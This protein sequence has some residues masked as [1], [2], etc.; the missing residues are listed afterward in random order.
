MQMAP[1]TVT[2]Q[3]GATFQVCRVQVSHAGGSSVR[4]TLLL[5]AEGLARPTAADLARSYSA[6]AALG[7]VASLR[8]PETGSVVVITPNA[9]G[10]AV[11]DVAMAAAVCAAS[12]GWDESP[13]MHVVVNERGWDVAPVFC[14]GVWTAAIV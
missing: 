14:D 3:S 12:W 9:S 4:V 5:D 7:I 10:E 2:L 6:S 13:R 11:E 8:I 1:E